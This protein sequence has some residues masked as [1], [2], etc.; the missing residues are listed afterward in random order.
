MAHTGSVLLVGC[1][2]AGVA[3][4]GGAAGGTAQTATLS[5]TPASLTLEPGETATVELVLSDAP[6]GVAG[7]DLTVSV[8]D[9]DLLRITEIQVADQFGIGEAE[10]TGEGWSVRGADTNDAVESGARA[11]TLAVITVEAVA[12]GESEIELQLGQ[13]DDDDGSAITP[14][15]QP[16]VVS[17]RSTESA[18][19]RTRSPSPSPTRSPSPDG[20]HST[21]QQSPPAGSEQTS[22]ADSGGGGPGSQTSVPGFGVAAATLAVLTATLLIRRRG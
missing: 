3:V 1:L 8:G 5:G 13:L 18:A 10:T 17:A 11:V 22:E 9:T 19:S 7:F 21:T 16:I 20:E 12:A 14:T 2:I 6:D 4:A 15:V